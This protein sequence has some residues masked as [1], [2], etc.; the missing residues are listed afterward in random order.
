MEFKQ[1][2]EKTLLADNKELDKVY[3]IGN[4][5]IFTEPI[6]NPFICEAEYLEEVERIENE[7]LAHEEMGNDTSDLQKVKSWLD[8]LA[9]EYI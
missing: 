8:K 1:G 7:I 4:G 5:G 9:Y 2:I 3:G 6:K